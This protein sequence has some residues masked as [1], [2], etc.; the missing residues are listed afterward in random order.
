[1]YVDIKN[2]WILYFEKSF[3]EHGTLINYVSENLRRIIII[4]HNDYYQ[5]SLFF[6]SVSLRVFSR[7]NHWSKYSHLYG[8]STIPL[9]PYTLGGIFDDAVRQAPDQMFVVSKHE[10]KR[11]T[12]AEMASEV[13]KNDKNLILSTFFFKRHLLLNDIHYIS[14]LL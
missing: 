13:S 12:F 10:N 7:K 5:C 4:F 2:V 8:A 14:F 3:P 11:Y 1:M 6:F 9:K